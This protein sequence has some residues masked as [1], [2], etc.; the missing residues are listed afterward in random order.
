MSGAVKR[1]FPLYIRRY[2]S[3]NENFEYGYPHS[4]A[5]LQFRLKM[6]RNKPHKAARHSTKC[7]VTDDGQLFPTVYH[8]IYC[9]K[10]LKL[11][12]RTSRYKIMYEFEC[13]F[14]PESVCLLRNWHLS[15]CTLD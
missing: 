2:T 9:H 8:R 4:N 13:S 3:A 14:C 5:F 11:S 1:D 7:D 12:N 6:E 10:F 15:K